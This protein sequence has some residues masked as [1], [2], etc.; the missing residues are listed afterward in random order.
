MSDQAKSTPVSDQTNN[1]QAV[2]WEKE[3]VHY[4][5]D[6]WKDGKFGCGASR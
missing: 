2:D 6:I 3:V 5:S 1:T 4:T